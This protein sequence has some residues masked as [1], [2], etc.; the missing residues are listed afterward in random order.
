[1]RKS[2]IILSLATLAALLACQREKQDQV[3]QVTEEVS[4]SEDVNAQFV[5]NVSTSATATK[6]AA[7][8][9]QYGSVPFRGMADAKLMTWASPDGDGSI[10]VEDHDMD[11]VYDLSSML[12]AG[13]ISASN[14]RRVLEMSL[15][16]MTNTL[17]FYGR[18]P[19]ATAGSD[20]FSKEDC[21][22]LLDE[23]FVDEKA[24]KANFQLGKRLQ[25]PAKF[26]AAEKLMAGILT[27]IMNTKLSI[28]NG[29]HDN[30][31]ADDVPVNG[32]NAYGFALDGTKTTV[33]AGGYPEISWINY[34]GDSSPILTTH[35]LYPAEEKLNNLY[36]QLTTI[37][38][39][40]LRAGSG[41]ATLRIITD[42]WSVINSVRCCSPTSKSEAVA[43]Y[44]AVV[45][46]EHLQKYFS[47]ASIGTAGEPVTGVVFQPIATIVTNFGA[48]PCWPGI[49]DS[50]KPSDNELNSIK[51]TTGVLYGF[52]GAFN[53]P[54][55]AAYMAYKTT[56]RYF[57]Y[58]QVFNVSA[59]DG[60]PGSGQEYNANNY[61]Y[62]AQLLYFGNSPLR[63]STKTHKT[64]EYPENSTDWNKDASWTSAEGWGGT[65]ISSST[66]AVAMTYDIKYGVSMLETK[67]GYAVATLKD[68][69][70]AIQKGLH[71]TLGDNEE[72]DQEIPVNDNSFKLTGIIIGG[73][74]Q[75][76]G[77][78]FLPRVAKK[79][80]GTDSTAVQY[81]FI[82]DRAIHTGATSGYPDS[83]SIPGA[84]NQTSN[85]NYT[86]VFDNYDAAAAAASK[87]Q[88]K[89]YVALEFQNCTGKDFFGN[90]NL[91]SN[92]GYFYLIGE[93]DP[94]NASTNI[95]WPTSGYV[96]PPY[97]TSGENKGKSQNVT[98][99]F[100]QDYVTTATFKFHTNSLKYAYLTVPDLRAS[101]LTLGL[102]VDIQWK[103][104]LVYNDV[105]L[106]GN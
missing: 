76:V 16:L 23:Y 83:Q 48:D 54:R 53:V 63:A 79:K 88:D 105:T 68:N 49:D 94:A 41:E 43:K 99:V 35:V 102:S 72:P 87:P 104:G 62:P 61:Y 55:G 56:G 46:H 14:S 75:N 89:V 101:S 27:N 57:Y 71:P 52:P 97:I 58:P 82:Y 37:A 100:V 50:F 59:V 39:G 9:V 17:L 44:F 47:A 64:S 67:V 3:D 30:I 65:H 11:R 74:P 12:A 5:F 13:S 96:I 66:R 25:D 2:L 22:G 73:Q 29:T 8:E 106:G 80:D 32:S 6:Q 34:A 81:G 95:T 84:L 69:N 36:N 18:S 42:L 91:I 7:A 38:S 33:D 1:M 93:L 60:R 20:G 51:T 70:H 77:W 40:E 78:N 90:F 15:P 86:V 10:L 4:G 28:T 26:L 92:N 45:V 103:Q 19:E 85:P 98:R 21:F 24:G 31:Y